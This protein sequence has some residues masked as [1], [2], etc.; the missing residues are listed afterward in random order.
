MRAAVINE[1]W[2]DQPQERFWME[3]IRRPE[4][5]DGIRAPLTKQAGGKWPYYELVQNVRDGDIVLHWDTSRPGQESSF[6]AFSVVDGSPYETDDIAY[7]DGEPTTGTEALLRAYTPLDPALPLSA[8]NLRYDEIAE[9]RD[10][11]QAGSNAPIYFP[12]NIRNDGTVRAMQGGYLTKFPVALFDVLPELRPALDALKSGK[13][14][15]QE[16]APVTKGQARARSGQS[17]SDRRQARESGYVADAVVRKAIEN[18]AVQLAIAY[19]EGLDYAW[20][21]VGSKR[22][23]DL[24]LIHK[25]T[26]EERHVEVK[27]STGAAETVELTHGEVKHAQRFQPTD[28]FVVHGINWSRVKEEVVATGGEAT[29]YADWCP[30]KESLKAIRFRHTVPHGGTAVH[31]L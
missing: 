19:Y 18:R 4:H 7:A 30:S 27:G 11:I 5:G 6:V 1:W 12:F 9:I 20:K 14:A 29:R 23:Y 13:E 3:T 31:G 21:D 22:P 28:L 17:R 15:G 26:G 16:G 8:L 2:A 10:N 24:H 25:Q